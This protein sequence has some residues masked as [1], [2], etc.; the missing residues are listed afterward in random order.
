MPDFY[1][2]QIAVS[3]NGKKTS[4]VNF[5]PGLNIICGPSDTGK[6]YVI[7]ILDYLF[8]SDHIPIDV[9]HENRKPKQDIQN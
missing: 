7:E 1:I 5:A 9:E 2:E 8:G 3:G 4:A 6:S